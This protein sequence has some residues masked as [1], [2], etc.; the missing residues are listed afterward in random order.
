MINEKKDKIVAYRAFCPSK[1]KNRYCDM[2]PMS[3]YTNFLKP[4]YKVGKWSREKRYHCTVCYVKSDDAKNALSYDS[5]ICGRQL[6]L[7]AVELS[8]IMEDEINM[9]KDKPII[10]GKKVKILYEIMRSEE[11]AED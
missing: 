10:I 8:S 4:P 9:M 11:N 6:A 7:C 1:F 2:S 3:W 5:R